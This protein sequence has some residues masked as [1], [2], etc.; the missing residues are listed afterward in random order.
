MECCDSVSDDG[1]SGPCI[2]QPPGICSPP[3]SML[4]LLQRENTSHLNSASPPNQGEPEWRKEV[5]GQ[6]K[7]ERRAI[8]NGLEEEEGID[9]KQVDNCMV[10][11]FSKRRGDIRKEHDE[12]GEEADEVEC[13]IICQADGSAYILESQS[14]LPCNVVPSSS[15]PPFVNT[16]HFS[17]SQSST[18]KSFDVF[19]PKNW[20]H[21]TADILALLT[22]QSKDR[23]PARTGSSEAELAPL[24]KEQPILV[25]FLCR[26][27]FSRMHAF[28]DHVSQHHNVMLTT[29]EQQLLS[30]QHTCAILQPLGPNNHPLLSFLEPK[31]SN[32]PTRLTATALEHNTV[33]MLSQE[34][35]ERLQISEPELPLQPS[36]PRV[37][38][39]TSVLSP[40]KDPSTLGREGPQ[41]SS[42]DGGGSREGEERMSPEVISTA[43]DGA[44][45][46]SSGRQ[47][48]ITELALSNQSNPKSPNSVTVA[49]SFMNNTKFLTDSEL[50]SGTSF[51]C[52]GPAPLSSTVQT[53]PVVTTPKE[54]SNQESAME[55]EPN[56]LSEKGSA[57]AKEPNGKP[58]NDNMP[59]V[60]NSDLPSNNSNSQSSTVTTP[61]TQ[62][63]KSQFEDLQVDVGSSGGLL[64]GGEQDFVVG[65]DTVQGSSYSFGGQINISHSRNS[66]KTLKCPKCNWHYKYQQ[67]LEAHMKEKHPDSDDGQCP[68]CASGQNHPRLARGETYTCGYKPFRCQVCQYSTT[69]KG[70][71]SIHMQSDKHLNNM[72]NLQSQTRPDAPAVQPNPLSHTPSTQNPSPSPSKAQGRASWR[73]EVCDY[74]TN[75]AR[76]LRIHM[77]SEKHTHNMLL[78][79]QNL[80]HMQR[81]HRQNAAELYPYC[82]PQTRL[83]DPAGAIQPSGD[84]MQGSPRKPVDEDP[85]EALFE[86]ALCGHFSSDSLVA[87]SQHLTTQ[88]SLPDADWRGTTGEAHLCRL[89]HYATPLRANFQL[90]CQ[91]DKHLQR[92]Q[93]AAHLQEASRRHGKPEEEEEWMLRCVAAGVQVQ[94]RCNACSY[95]ANSMEKL[96]LHT[97]NTRHKA[98]LRLYKVNSFPVPLKIC[99]LIN[100]YV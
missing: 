27:S 37:P 33:A 43:E 93:L 41:R 87:L 30:L 79:Q 31:T 97:M 23:A 63:I 76:N 91:T 10:V 35:G 82:Q 51:N 46:I 72:Q 42:D 40:A 57:M 15:R 34:D 3:S 11:D 73:C 75:V 78:L 6:S 32:V 8:E 12:G 70:N 5:K 13:Q 68:Y 21:L 22:C 9:D 7:G 49:T 67:T 39:P 45:G 25:C 50:E 44:S 62:T 54:I 71:L 28:R 4:L 89:C 24:G 56:N 38:F 53:S 47:G 74:E 16:C 29:E 99:A 61:L 95:E 52:H 48:H 1:A 69:T 100:D 19:H 81:Q 86:C 17:S 80:A 90:H 94:L 65:R 88:R 98:S 96:K 55:I 58:C 66:C 20:C 36:L 14:R 77:T 92:Y 26:L 18:F 59:D 64:A 83:P 60:T 85:P 2:N 84:T